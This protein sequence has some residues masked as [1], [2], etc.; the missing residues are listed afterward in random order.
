MVTFILPSHLQFGQVPVGFAHLCSILGHRRMGQELGV[1][2]SKVSLTQLLW[3][4]VGFS[5]WACGLSMWLLGFLISQWLWLR[6]KCPKRGGGT[7]GNYTAF[8]CLVLEVMHYYFCH[9]LIIRRWSVRLAHIKWEA[10][11]SP[12]FHGMSV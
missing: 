1:Q 6:D 7:G 5:V 2:S 8:S 9:F 11:F 10:N 12:S 3:L 4:L